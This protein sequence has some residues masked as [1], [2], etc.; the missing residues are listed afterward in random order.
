MLFVP[1]VHLVQWSLLPVWHLAWSGHITLSTTI[2]LGKA[3]GQGKANFNITPT[4][5]CMVK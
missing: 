1:V 2:S 4:Y 3:K 5:N